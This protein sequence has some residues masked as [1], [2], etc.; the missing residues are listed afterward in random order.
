M[1]AGV[2]NRIAEA[3]PNFL[4][5]MRD[6]LIGQVVVLVFPGGKIDR[7]DN[8]ESDCPLFKDGTDGSEQKT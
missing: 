8:A 6:E 7:V 1:V 3:W 4:H 2:S 5:G